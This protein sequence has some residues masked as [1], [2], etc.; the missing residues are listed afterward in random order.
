MLVGL[1][2]IRNIIILAGL[3]AFSAVNKIQTE[4][5]TAL[6]NP[7]TLII[8]I[9]ALLCAFYVMR[10]VMRMAGCLIS[11]LV[12]AAI[13]GG[14]FFVLTDGQMDPAKLSE[15]LG[16]LVPQQTETTPKE[17][18]APP[19]IEMEKNQPEKPEATGFDAPLEEFASG[20]EVTPEAEKPDVMPVSEQEK[21]LI[22]VEKKTTSSADLF[23]AAELEKEEI[24]E[25]VKQVTFDL[26]NPAKKEPKPSPQPAPQQKKLTSQSL[27][28]TLGGMFGKKKTNGFVAQ[29]QSQQQA[30][31][32]PQN[33]QPQQRPVLKGRAQTLEGDT[34]SIGGRRVRLF[35]IDAPE[36]SQ[37][38]ADRTGSS[39]ACG[40]VARR[41]LRKMVGR[42]V[43]SCK[44]MEQDGLGNVIAACSNGKFDLGA[45]L[46]S[47][48]WAVAYRKFSPLYVP[49]EQ[50]ARQQRSGLW[51]GSFYMPWDWR[52]Y[53]IDRAEQIKKMRQNSKRKGRGVLGDLLNR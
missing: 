23:N 12:L 18:E 9:V 35:G 19:E 29:S 16:G 5:M 28:Q 26:L 37:T 36:M 38:C 39:F 10:M 44:V 51:K 13:V 2:S 14:T 34:L 31:V 50:K 49:Y 43:L 3:G 48:G 32:Q 45:A 8:L 47:S 33:R 4:G 53:E 17:G 25:D 11:V 22:E 46:V 1:F 7:T 6:M 30:A 41:E 21:P 52:Q 42:S 15:V 40:E 24:E 20:E 27:T